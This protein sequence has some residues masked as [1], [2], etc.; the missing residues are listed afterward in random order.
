MVECYF[1]F[2]IPIIRI[3]SDKSTYDSIQCEINKAIEIIKQT[4]DSTS[5]TYL[6]TGSPETSISNKTYDFVEKFQ[7][8]NLKTRI[9]DAVNEYAGRIGWHGEKDFVLRNSWI[10]LFD[11]DTAHGQHCHPG[12]TISGV[13]YH[14]VSEKQ[15][16]L[17]FNNPNSLMFACNFPQG[18]VCPQ[19]VDIVPDNGDIILFPSWLVHSTRKNATDEQRISVA[20]NLDHVENDKIA[21]GLAKQSHRPYHKL[22]K[23]LKNIIEE[24]RE[25]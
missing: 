10:N 6:Y 8:N 25:S 20:F 4:N 2:P 3:H 9:Y 7:C 17:S 18:A 11:K 12:Y 16:T 23:S 24:Y 22:E 21:F 15:G 19:T 13:Y 1:L 14:Q 5:L